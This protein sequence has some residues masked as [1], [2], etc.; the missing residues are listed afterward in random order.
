MYS[1]AIPQEEDWVFLLSWA[2]DLAEAF[3]LYLKCNQ[4]LSFFLSSCVRVFSAVNKVCLEKADSDPE[5]KMKATALEI[6]SIY[7]N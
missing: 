1:D 4:C 7:D 5:W 2:L 6:I 3:S